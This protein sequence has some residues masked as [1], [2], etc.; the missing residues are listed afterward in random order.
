MLPGIE[1]MTSPFAATLLLDSFPNVPINLPECKKSFCPTTWP[2]TVIISRVEATSIALQLTELGG[3]D[4]KTDFVKWHLPI[5]SGPNSLFKLDRCNAVVLV[6]IYGRV[7]KYGREFWTPCQLECQSSYVA[8]C[9]RSA[10][11][12]WQQIHSFLRQKAK[13]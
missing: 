7:Q 8:P 4:A 12:R 6:T 11:W 13:S 10:A 1:A 9:N 5:C 2:E 3:I